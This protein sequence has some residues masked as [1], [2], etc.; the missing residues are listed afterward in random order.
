QHLKGKL[1]TNDYNLNKVAQLQDVTVINLNDLANAM[2]PSFLP[3]EQISVRVVK[4]GEEHGQ[5]IGYL[6]DGTMVVIESGREHIGQ[7]VTIAVTSVIQK[8][9]GRMVF[10]RFDNPK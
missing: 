10:G 4:A 9:A 2:K 8:S 7:Q 3:G 1:I 6:D 5:G